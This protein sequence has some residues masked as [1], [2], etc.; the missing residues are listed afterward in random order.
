M[1]GKIKGKVAEINGNESLIETQSGLFYR[2]FL[3][4][5]LIQ[6]S[7]IEK[8]VEIYTYLQ[9]REDDWSLYGFEDS[10]QYEIFKMLLNVDKVGPK[11]AY[12]IISYAPSEQITDAVLKNDVVFFNN[13]PGIGKKTAQKVLL[14]LSSKLGSEFDSSKLML[15]QEDKTV[16]DALISLGFSVREANEAIRKIEPDLPVENKI[17]AAIKYISKK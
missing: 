10:R 5:K 11:L 12:T 8:D 15:N 16:V 4:P 2:V 7:E 9:V 6:T 1:I 14:E 3:T 13:I 17:Q